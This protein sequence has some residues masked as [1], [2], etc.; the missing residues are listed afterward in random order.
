MVQLYTSSFVYSS[1]DGGAVEYKKRRTSSSAHHMFNSMVP[2]RWCNAKHKWTDKSS[3]KLSIAM[4]KD[5]NAISQMLVF[6]YGMVVTAAVRCGSSIL[7]CSISSFSIAQ[8]K[9][10]RLQDLRFWRLNISHFSISSS[11]DFIRA[12]LS[13]QPRFVLSFV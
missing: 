12:F 8:L 1:F 10:T 6:R 4:V 3:V 13:S 5:A 2:L 7:S 9:H 11:S